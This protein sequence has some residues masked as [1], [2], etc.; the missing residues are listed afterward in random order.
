MSRIISALEHQSF[1]SEKMEQIHFIT[2]TFF[3][4]FFLNIIGDSLNSLAFE[5]DSLFL[6]SNRVYV[7]SLI[8]RGYSLKGV[9]PH[10]A[11]LF[12]LRFRGLLQP[13]AIF[14]LALHVLLHSFHQ[15]LQASNK[16]KNECIASSSISKVF[17]WGLGSL[18][19]KFW[20]KLKET[21]TPFIWKARMKP[22]S[23]TRSSVLKRNQRALSLI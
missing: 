12:G 7:A 14:H 8:S 13:P 6:C 10:W 15:I 2:L 22:S 17:H 23:W 21:T 4:C 16:P 11:G 19:R 3:L 18:V 9:E 5:K 1:F 20:S